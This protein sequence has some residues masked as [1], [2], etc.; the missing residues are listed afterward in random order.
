MDFFDRLDR[1]KAR[2][3]SPATFCGGEAVAIGSCR[4]RR[5]RRPD[6]EA[7]KDYG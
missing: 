2:V 1:L 3:A 4:E 5:R 7:A 6:H